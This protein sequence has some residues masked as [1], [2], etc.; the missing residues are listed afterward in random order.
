MEIIV[1]IETKS[2][3]PNAHILTIAAIKFNSLAP[4]S[5]LKD[6]DT[7]YRRIERKS[8]EELGMH[9]DMDTVNW[10][11][12]QSAEAR[13]EAFDHPDRVPIK[14]ALR[15]FSNWFG[16]NSNTLLWSRGNNFDPVILNSAYD[17]CELNPPWKYWNVRDVRTLLDAGGISKYDL[18]SGNDHHSL[19]DCYRDMVGI[20]L[21]MR[22]IRGIKN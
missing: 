6:L 20:K 10:W 14:E 12:K 9:I 11:R 16:R 7:F 1:D 21:A 2:T 13:F 19:H 22:R 8:C 15:A 17:A 3:K 18:P 5:E 4:P